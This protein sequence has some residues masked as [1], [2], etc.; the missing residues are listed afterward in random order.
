MMNNQQYKGNVAGVLGNENRE[1]SSPQKSSFS[2]MFFVYFSAFLLAVIIVGGFFALQDALNPEN[3]DENEK[4]E[5]ITDNPTPFP[6]RFPTDFPTRFPTDFPTRFPTFP[7]TDFP[8]ERPT[9]EEEKDEIKELCRT[10]TRGTRV[11]AKS[12]DYISVVFDSTPNSADCIAFMRAASRLSTAV[13]ETFNDINFSPSSSFRLS[14][15][16]GLTGNFNPTVFPAFENIKDLTIV[17]LLDSIDGA[18]GILAAAGPCIFST[19]FELPLAGVM[20]FDTDDTADLSIFGKL[21]DVVLHEMMHVLGFGSM[22]SRVPDGAGGFITSTDVLRDEVYVIN[23][24]GDIVS[25]NSNNQPKFIG[26]SGIEEFE[27]LTGEAESFVPVQGVRLDGQVIFNV[28]NDEGRGSVDSHIDK[29][30]FQD[31]LMTFA[32]DVE[33]G[34]ASPL[35]AMSLKMLEDIGYDVNVTVADLYSLESRRLIAEDRNLR[36][37]KEYLFDL[38]GDVLN[39]VP[40]PFGV[41]ASGVLKFQ[42]VEKPKSIKQLFNLED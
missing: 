14:D 38:T 10:V 21:E 26:S 42:R 20:I 30:T 9:T 29:D 13:A 31:E 35:S 12:S 36:A 11:Q 17:A 18:G 40:K 15:I 22:W 28:F 3:S 4:G 8:T 25:R 7:P 6:T 1:A 19:A 32:V 41:D 2:F 37:E 16:C 5:D 34:R 33:S 23:G 27:E 24:F 39:F